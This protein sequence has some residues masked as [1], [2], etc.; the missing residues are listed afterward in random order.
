[1]SIVNNG[2]KNEL[3]E[4]QIPTGYTRPSITDFTD[5]EYIRTEEMTILKATVEDATNA[6]TMTNII[7]EAVI[8]ITKQVDTILANDYVAS[9][10]VE[11]FASMTK[12]STNISDDSSGDGVWLGNTAASYTARVAIYIKTS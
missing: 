12:L 3:K 8:G 4:S 9:N 7:E 2:T 10:N 11:A 1:M 5:F 6:T